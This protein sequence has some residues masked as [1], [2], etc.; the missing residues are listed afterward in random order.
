MARIFSNLFVFV[1]FDYVLASLIHDIAL[2]G[3][4]ILCVTLMLGVAVLINLFQEC[5][6]AKN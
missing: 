1:S 5:R 2:H 3:I 6:E 4:H